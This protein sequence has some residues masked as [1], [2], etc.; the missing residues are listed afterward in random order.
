M[1]PK[2]VDT[3]L[4]VVVHDPSGSY[5]EGALVDRQT[6]SQLEQLQRVVTLPVMADHFRSS[7]VGG[8]AVRRWGAG[9][10][11]DSRAPQMICPITLFCVPQVRGLVW[12][13]RVMPNGAPRKQYDGLLRFVAD[14][15]QRTPAKGSYSELSDRVLSLRDELPPI[16]PEGGW[17]I[18]GEGIISA[19]NEG[20]YGFSLYASAPGL[21][22]V[23]VA[24][25]L[26]PVQA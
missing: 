1:G 22:A 17:T 20:H 8:F 9:V 26:A 4:H 15:G 2:I 21:L 12:K 13:A 7:G 6:A 16:D 19:P 24:C 25:S 23:W 11:L 18:G 5:W 3:P 10:P 14:S